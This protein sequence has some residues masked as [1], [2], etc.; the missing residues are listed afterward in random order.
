[1]CCITPAHCVFAVMTVTFGS[2]QYFIGEG[3][4]SIVLQV[5]GIFTD[6]QLTTLRVTLAEGT[7]TGW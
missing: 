2:D 7:A 3:A 4:G 6:I 1:M 5:H